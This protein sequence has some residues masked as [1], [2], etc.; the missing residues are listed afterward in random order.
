MPV[1]EYECENDHL[2]AQANSV[3]MRDVAKCPECG[4]KSVRRLFG[5]V[6]IHFKGSGWGK[7]EPRK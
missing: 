7:D 3:D 4:L 5:V 6:G 2:W 1:Y